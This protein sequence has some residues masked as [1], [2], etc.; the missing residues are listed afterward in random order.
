VLEYRQD[1]WRN[2]KVKVKR[3]RTAIL[4]AVGEDEAVADQVLELVKNQREY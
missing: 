3:V 2:N 1:D 4:S